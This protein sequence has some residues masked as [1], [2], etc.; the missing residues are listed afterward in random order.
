MSDVM[1]GSTAILSIC[2][3]PYLQGSPATWLSSRF[4]LQ[5]Y[6]A[7]SM[8]SL[9]HLLMPIS[10][11]IYSAKAMFFSYGGYRRYGPRVLGD[12]DDDLYADPFKFSSERYM[13]GVV[14]AAPGLPSQPRVHLA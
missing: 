6:P 13:M 3:L 1:R 2:R 14:M 11:P 4:I 9:V 12:C 8:E 7:V 10:M 5:D